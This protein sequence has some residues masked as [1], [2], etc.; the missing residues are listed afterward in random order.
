MSAHVCPEYD[1][2]DP[3]LMLFATGGLDGK[4]MTSLIILFLVPEEKSERKGRMRMC[5]SGF[6]AW[7]SF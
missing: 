1:D 7:A 3:T 5:Q 6:G 2:T 4:S